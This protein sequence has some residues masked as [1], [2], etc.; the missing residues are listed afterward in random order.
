MNA[1]IAS[2]LILAAFDLGPQSV[3]DS[4][5]EEED[6]TDKDLERD[7]VDF[8]KQFILTNGEEALENRVKSLIFTDILDI[9]HLQVSQA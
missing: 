7:R 9:T 1:K 4:N 2:Q 3:H 5:D 8:D 6:E